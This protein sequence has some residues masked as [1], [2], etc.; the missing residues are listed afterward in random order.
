MTRSR[1][2]TDRHFA[3]VAAARRG[4]DQA[5]LALDPCLPY[6]LELNDA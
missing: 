4:L 5:V 3:D 2:T 6:V 1:A